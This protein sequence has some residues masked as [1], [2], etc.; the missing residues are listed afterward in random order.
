MID[1][2]TIFWI[3]VLLMVVW[4]CRSLIA[5]VGLAILACVGSA[6]AGIAIGFYWVCDKISKKRRKK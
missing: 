4:S 6:I 3:I 1:P 2:W 5:I